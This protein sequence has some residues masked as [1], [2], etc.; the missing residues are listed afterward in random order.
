MSEENIENLSED[1]PTVIAEMEK[2]CKNNPDN[3][4]AFHHLGLV[5][6]KAGRIDE[7][8]EALERCIELDD[9]ANQPMI[10]LGAIYFGMGN[11]DKAQ[12]LVGTSISV[13]EGIA[14]QTYSSG[15]PYIS[16]DVSED[17]TFLQDVDK[18]TSY[19]SISIIAAPITSG[20]APSAWTRYRGRNTYRPFWVMLRSPAIAHSAST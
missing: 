16:E 10:N 18:R 19:R 15:E 9:Q 6:M 7:A 12:E 11:L 14:G 5:Y 4:V 1:L 20:P 2:K 8:I 3:V 13:N 17:E